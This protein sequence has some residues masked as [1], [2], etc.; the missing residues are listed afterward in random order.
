M[1]KYKPA[2]DRPLINQIIR[3]TRSELGLS[4]DE[5]AEKMGMKSDTYSKKERLGNITVEWAIEFANAVGVSPEIFKEVFNE[6]KENEPLIFEPQNGDKFNLNSPKDFIDTIYGK[7][8]PQQEKKKK[9][10]TYELDST[11]CTIIDTFRDFSKPKRAE[12]LTALNNI[13][14]SK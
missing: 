10:T 2:S 6:K 8:K 13:K 1:S 9:T 14:D 3:K 7:A 4:Q 12:A 11:E 5:V